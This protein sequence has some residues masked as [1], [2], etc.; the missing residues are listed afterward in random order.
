MINNFNS[1]KKNNNLFKCKYHDI[2]STK[3]FLVNTNF[4]KNSKLNDFSIFPFYLKN[5]S[6]CSYSFMNYNNIT[7]SIL[8]KIGTE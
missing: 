5:S 2:Q 1:K 7:K 3:F 4:V 8:W 6:S